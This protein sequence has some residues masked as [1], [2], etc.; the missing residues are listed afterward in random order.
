M[1]AFQHHNVQAAHRRG[2]DIDQN[3]RLEADCLQLLDYAE[4]LWD[5]ARDC[6]DHIIHCRSG[7]NIALGRCHV[8]QLMISRCS[9][10]GMVDTYEFHV[11]SINFH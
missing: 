2:L 11:A 5:V 4:F 1:L 10:L 3:H 8:T 9:N 6:C 7:G